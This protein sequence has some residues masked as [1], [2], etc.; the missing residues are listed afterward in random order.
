M[1]SPHA[2]ERLEHA[3]HVIKDAVEHPSDYGFRQWSGWILGPAVLILTCLVDP[4]SGLS[5]A[6]WRT[7]GVAGLM[8]ILWMTESIPLP[9]TALLPLVLFPALDLTDIREAA[10]PY[11]NPLIFLFL[12]G[13]IIALAMQ[14]WN[15]HRR[16]AINLLGVMGTRPSRVVGGIL[17]SSALVSMWVSNT[18]TALMMLPIALSIV[19]LVPEAQRSTPAMRAFGIALMLAVAYGSTVGGMATLIGTPPIALLAGYLDNTFHYKI[20]FGQW[21]LLGVP[22]MLI[23]LPIVFFVVTRVSFRLE[24]QELPGMSALI[25]RER[26]RLGPFSRGETIVAIVF[27]LTALAWI[28]QPLLARSIPLVND[29]TIAMTGAILLFLIPVDPRRGQF[30]MDW[31][32]VKNLPWDVLLLFGGGLTIAAAMDKHG[33]SPYIGQLCNGL[34][35]LPTI[36]TVAILCF[37]M[38]ILT[39]LASNTAAAAT[40]CPIAASIAIGM[41]QNPLLFVIPIV[42]AASCS[43]ML[44]VGTP[45]N[46]IV[47]SSGLVR[48]PEMAR[49]GFILNVS[50]VPVI[51]ALVWV[52]GRFVFDIELG[53]LPDWAV[54]K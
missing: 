44:P 18:A 23:S 27:S 51:V 36:A 30:V 5:E 41:G 20:G 43:F 14:R 19:Q 54:Q 39:E 15:L 32:A 16:V 6:G 26:S 31:D 22:M 24:R 33:L 17:L 11:A 3:G 29:T 7:A 47:F 9:V 48:L 49:A 2:P 37:G 28:F 38:L 34:A 1:S 13:F 45:P 10:A 50:L 42:L 52:L 12:G 21:M 35:G 8:A 40:F 4:P 46:A 53:T 25:V